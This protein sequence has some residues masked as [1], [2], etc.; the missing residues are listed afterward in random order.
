MSAIA[1]DVRAEY[2]D[3][4][5]YDAENPDF[6]PDGSFYLALA[7]ESGGPVLDL[8]CG[9]GRIAIPLARAGFDVTGVDVMPE[10]LAHARQKSGDLSVRWVEADARAFTLETRFSL[11]IMAGSFQHFLT[12]ADQEAALGRV[13][14]HL[15]PDGR[16]VIVL[17]FP[18]PDSLTPSDEQEWMAYTTPDGRAVTVSGFEHYDPV[19]Q[20]KHETAIRRWTGPDGTP[21]ET[22]APMALRF[23]FPQEIDTL[24]HYNGLE[25][26]ERCGAPDRSPLSADSRMMFLVCRLRK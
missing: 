4:A 6:D 9:T 14:E 3:P 17:W 18:H 2:S 24:L 8:C 11:I 23:L 10:M 22:R 19:R 12:R 5:L 1:D 21:V 26:V 25:I 13:R 16:C 7:Q 15:A 20:I